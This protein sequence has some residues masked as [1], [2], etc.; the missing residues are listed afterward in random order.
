[1]THGRA[2]RSAIVLLALAAAPLRGQ[3]PDGSPPP[4]AR[5]APATVPPTSLA[6]LYFENASHDTADAYL[7]DGI[8]EEISA[9]FWDRCEQIPACKRSC[10]GS[11]S[12]GHDILVTSCSGSTQASCL[13]DTPALTC[14][15]PAT[16]AA[17]RA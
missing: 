13:L 9:G 4:C 3:C 16:L 6:V 11:D 10:R 12:P 1:M 8:T 14:R 2:V 17:E 15:V 5:A 7:A